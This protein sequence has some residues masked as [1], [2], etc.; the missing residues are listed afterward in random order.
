[1]PLKNRGR[2]Y[3]TQRGDVSGIIPIP[4]LSP[5]NRNWRVLW[6]NWSHV[7]FWHKRRA[8]CLVERPVY[9]LAQK[10]N[11]IWLMTY[12]FQAISCTPHF[13]VMLV[14]AL[15]L[16]VL[17]FLLYVYWWKQLYQTT[18]HLRI[19]CWKTPISITEID[20]HLLKWIITEQLQK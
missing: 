18:H 4:K 9:L 3:W 19:S 10:S 14:A 5:K 2:C 8:K 6:N 17:A 20:L 12:F 11:S 15:N 13:I 7:R 16:A 1:M